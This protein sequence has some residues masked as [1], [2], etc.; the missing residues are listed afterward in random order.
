MDNENGPQPGSKPKVETI[1][2]HRVQTLFPNTVRDGGSA[3]EFLW[4][5]LPNPSIVQRIGAWLIS[6][7]GIGGGLAFIIGGIHSLRRDHSWANFAASVVIAAVFL[8][9][10]GWNLRLGFPKR[11]TKSKGPPVEFPGTQI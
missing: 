4:K 10:G 7:I 11:R 6:S 5:G 1:T 8:V 9:Y 3:E 2:P